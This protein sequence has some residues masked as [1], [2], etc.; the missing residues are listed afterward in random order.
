MPSAVPGVIL[1]GQ[2][3]C[4]N[5]EEAVIVARCLPR[6][7][8][9]TRAEPGCISFVVRRIGSLIWQVD[10][11][12]VDA[13]AFESHQKR[14]AGSDWGRATVGIERRYTIEADPA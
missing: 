13:K 4:T 2:L 9:L 12:F 14:S 10:E 1:T 8:Q 5:D 6:H 11:R 7:V 3:V